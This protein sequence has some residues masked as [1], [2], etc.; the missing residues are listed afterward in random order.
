M[1][2]M[3]LEPG[4]YMMNQQYV[5][6]NQMLPDT[7]QQLMGAKHRQAIIAIQAS[8]NYSKF[9][10]LMVRYHFSRLRRNGSNL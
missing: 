5:R 8:K 2:N 4:H 10:D 1:Q 9:H 6:A 3:N 7:G